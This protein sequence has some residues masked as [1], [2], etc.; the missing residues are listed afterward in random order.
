MTNPELNERRSTRSRRRRT[1]AAVAA[2][3]SAALGSALSYS[4]P[5]WA[6]S[7]QTV[8]VKAIEGANGKMRFDGLP[9]TLKGGLVRFELT[10]TGKEPHDLQIVRIDGVHSNTDVIKVVTAD[11]GPTP[12]WLHADG[13]VNTIAPGGAGS[14]TVNLGAGKYLFLCTET[15][16]ETKVVHASAGMAFNVT[17]SGA[18]A[19]SLPTGATAT[20]TAKEY[21]FETKGLKAGKNV[22][23]FIDAGKELHHFQ[24]FPIAAGKTI[25]D[26]K[27][28]LSSN[29]APTGPPP[30]DFEKGVGSS[31]IEK[32]EGSLLTEITLTAGRYAMLCFIQDRT[33]GPPHF[34]KGMLT[35]IVIK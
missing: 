18:K 6:Q 14:A 26:V 27:T 19:A 3:L 13:G 31:V 9:A 16:D 11:G 12:S 7:V 8:K 10:N 28:F 4:G 1:S 32:S 17:V 20:V 23:E 2:I 21:G 15:N 33:G 24:M 25:A 34:M 35:E 30:V 5:V 29:G 22:V